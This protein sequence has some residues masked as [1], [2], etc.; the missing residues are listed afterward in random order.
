M[1]TTFLESVSRKYGVRKR[2]APEILQALT[3]YHYPGNVRELENMLE[4]LA[5]LSDGEVIQGPHLALCA[6]E[7]ARRD[8]PVDTT[9]V[10]RLSDLHDLFEERV[11]RQA[12]A[13][14]RT[15]REAAARLEISVPTLWRKLRKHDLHV[16]RIVKG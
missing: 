2:L 7:A 4:R 12:L 1:I 14:C 10:S 11:L 9:L 13:Q 8:M 16:S 15:M 5:I 3:D 6:F